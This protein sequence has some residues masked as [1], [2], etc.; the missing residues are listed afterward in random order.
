MPNQ[1]I[2]SSIHSVFVYS[3]LFYPITHA[4]QNFFW[5]IRRDDV[6]PDGKNISRKSTAASLGILSVCGVGDASLEQQR[7]QHDVI[8]AT[9]LRMKG[10][11]DK[12]LYVL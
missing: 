11:S 7:A 1:L 4:W 9:F 12:V 2:H 3:Y 8:G 5:L 6:A 10:F